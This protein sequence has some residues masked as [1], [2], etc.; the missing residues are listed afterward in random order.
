V[1]VKYSVC[2]GRV[3]NVKELCD[4][5]VRAAECI[6]SAMLCHYE[7]VSK[8]FRTESTTK[9]TRTTINTIQ[10]QHKGYGGKTHY[11]DS[12]NSDTTAP[13]GT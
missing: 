11:T 1:F 3:Q 5:I 8:S 4:R 10:K 2:R 6:T 9:Y 13:S 12:Q 7:G